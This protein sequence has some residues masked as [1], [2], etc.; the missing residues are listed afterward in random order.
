MNKSFVTLFIVIVILGLGAYL[1]VLTQEPA[2]PTSGIEQPGAGD[3]N[4]RS[5]SAEE[6]VRANISQLSPESAV[7]GGTFY[8]TRVEAEGGAGIVEYEDGHIAF[9]ADFTY[10]VDSDGGITITSFIVREEERTE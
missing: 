3:E 7:L 10:E 2:Q 5:I 1:Y 9:V 6:Y 8:V 4:G